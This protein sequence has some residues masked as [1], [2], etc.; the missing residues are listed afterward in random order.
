MFR[1]IDNNMANLKQPTNIPDKAH[2]ADIKYVY[3][4]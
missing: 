2:H 4:V 3:K 1:I